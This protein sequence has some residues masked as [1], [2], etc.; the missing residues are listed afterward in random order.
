MID[1]HTTC[2]VSALT[3][4]FIVYVLKFMRSAVAQFSLA[5][6]L[7]VGSFTLMLMFCLSFRRAKSV[8]S[9]RMLNMVYYYISILTFGTYLCM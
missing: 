6:Y 4:I 5:E 8:A 3:K 7:Y 9:P 1:T 2:Y